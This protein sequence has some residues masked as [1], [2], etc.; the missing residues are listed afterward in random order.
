MGNCCS[1]DHGGQSAVGGT[2]ASLQ[3]LAGGSN[4][5]V[6]HFLKSRGYHVLFTQIELSLSATNLRDR[7]V[8]SKSDPMAVLYVKGRDGTLDEI[9]RTEVV[10]NSLNPL[11]I[12][13]HTIAY[14]FE[15]VQS[16]VF[17]VYDVDTV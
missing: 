1:D 12:T 17:R 3:N 14:H 11:W 4:D 16:L 13:K 2:V 9:G 8:L 15:V 5:I 10:L 7:D 6:D